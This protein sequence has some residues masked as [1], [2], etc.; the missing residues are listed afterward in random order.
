MSSRTAPGYEHIQRSWRHSQEGKVVGC[1]LDCQEGDTGRRCIDHFLASE[2]V[3]GFRWK[4]NE[5]DISEPFAPFLPLIEQILKQREIAA[6]SLLDAISVKGQYRD[7]LENYF[8]NKPVRRRELPIPD[9]LLYEQNYVADLVVEMLLSLAKE[10]PLC[11]AISDLQFVGPSSYRVLQRLLEST[12]EASCFLVISLEVDHMHPDERLQESWLRFLDWL[13]SFQGRLTLTNTEVLALYQQWPESPH[14]ISKEPRAMLRDC[15]SLLAFMCLPE[16]AYASEQVEREFVQKGLTHDTNSRLHLLAFKGHCL[17]YLGELDEAFEALDS[18]LEQAQLSSDKRALARAYRHLCWAYV[19][20]QDLIQALNCG[21]QAVNYSGDLADQRERAQCLFYYFV[22]CAKAHVAFGMQRFA[23]MLQLLQ[24]QGMDN[25]VIFAC[26]SIYAQIEHTTELSLK[27]AMAASREATR[28]ARDINQQAGLAAS[29]NS[30]AVLLHNMGLPHQAKRCFGISERLLKRIDDPLDMARLRNGFGYFYCQQEQFLLAYDYFNGALQQVLKVGNVNETVASL[31][32]LAWLYLV[33]RDYRQSGAVLEKLRRLMV[34]QHAS[35]FSFRNLHDVHL[36]QGLVH[37][38]TG[39]WLRAGQCLERSRRLSIPLSTSAELVLPMLK[40][41]LKVHTD[42]EAPSNEALARIEAEFESGRRLASQHRLIWLEVKVRIKLLCGKADECEHLI[43]SDEQVK[44]SWPLGWQSIRQFA[45]G[46]SKPLVDL[47]LPAM[48]LEHLVALAQQEAR[49]NQLWKR[50][51]EVRLISALQAIGFEAKSEQQI[52]RESIRLLCA[53]Y[54]FQLAM[55]VNCQTEEPEVMAVHVDGQVSDFPIDE[56]AG[57]VADFRNQQLL[58]NRSWLFG[59]TSR[60]LGVVCVM[61]LRDGNFRQAQLV[62]VNIEHHYTPGKHDQEVLTLIANQMSAQLSA[63]RQ[64]NKLI[65]LSSIDALTGLANR[66]SLQTTMQ[67][68]INRVRR[69]SGSAGVMSLAFIDLDNFKYYNDTFGHDAGDLLLQWFAELLLE[70]LRD[71]DVAGRWGGDEFIVFMPETG[72]A[73]A[74]M[75]GQ[76]I[77]TALEGLRGFQ[78]RLSHALKRAINIPEEKW[79]RCSVGIT[80]TNYEQ[81]TPEAS[82]MLAEADKALYK[83]KATGKGK[84]LRF[85]G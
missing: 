64:Q 40:L 68:E 42:E 21:R 23:N 70:Q 22:A 66:Q 71:V 51:R 76:R 49:L 27:Q 69:Y 78:E 77:L 55:V 26:R 75:V 15:E 65:E 82:A 24:Q 58:L 50:M 19:Y 57:D 45:Q 8:R 7:I 5:R 4:L 72:A 81:Q 9:D 83:A 25:A 52:A 84:V 34:G 59:A 20:K 54:D 29:Y 33:V 13:D 47:P 2:A 14:L 35:Y 44:Q 6:D 73:P 63:V 67:D 79:L 61:P 39:E 30:R 12:D 60:R 74:A 18:I 3:V 28:V 43:D 62:L 85:E 32:N 1:F 10:Q 53:H 37:A 46:K 16:A 36:M 48:A 80:E 56:L 38:F 31:Y 41:L 17:L 11:L